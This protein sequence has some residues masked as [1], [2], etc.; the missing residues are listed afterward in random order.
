M[1]SHRLFRAFVVSSALAAFPGGSSLLAEKALRLNEV[2]P[3]GPLGEWVEVYNTSAQTENLENY[4][5]RK[6]AVDGK[7]ESHRVGRFAVPGGKYFVMYTSADRECPE[8]PCLPF[9]LDGDGGVVSL[10]WSPPCREDLA[11]LIDE[12]RYP[13]TQNRW[14]YGR[15]PAP[16]FGTWCLL[17]APTRGH[18]NASCLAVPG[19]VR[20]NEVSTSES[21]APATCIFGG[22][23][24][25]VCAERRN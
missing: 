9:N 6:E 8:D 15:L 11:A 1:N 7:S 23:P 5:L 14:S 19:P 18:A 17:S 10:E 2:Y 12:V 20:I 24:D 13:P 21:L 4:V 16:G 22:C 25:W 3:A